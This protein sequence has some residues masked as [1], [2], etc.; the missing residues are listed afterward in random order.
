ME[1][2]AMAAAANRQLQETVVTGLRRG[3]CPTLAAPMETGDGLLVR[4]RPAGG[5]L[6][7][8]QLKA[9]AS[10]AASCGNGILEIT[11]RGNLQVR[12]LRPD[13]V[14]TLALAIDAAGIVVPPGPAI[15][16]SPLHGIDSAE[17]GDAAALEAQLRSTLAGKLQSA[18]IA[19]KLAIL[20]DGRGVFCLDH[21]SADIRIVALAGHDWLVAAGGTARV[22]WHVFS[23]GIDGAVTAVGHVLDILIATGRH[24]RARDIDIETLHAAFP[25]APQSISFSPSRTP[26]P[27][28][29]ALPDGRAVLGLRPRFG[30]MRADALRAFLADLADDIEIRLA[31]DRQLFLTGLAAAEAETLAVRAGSCGFSA[32]PVDPSANIAACAGAGA[33]ASGFYDTRKLAARIIDTAPD[34]LDGSLTVHLSG[35]AKGCAHP[36]AALTLAGRGNAY[37]LSMNG[38]AGDPPDATIA[39]GGIESAIERLAQLAGTERRAGETVAACLQRLGASTIAKALQ[40]D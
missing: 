16:L 11:A 5:A 3:A 8:A 1:G 40:Q 36:Q 6:T 32:D 29:L 2:C 25:E 34:L 9:L 39:G 31:P 35:C 33:C 4:L 15:E 38:K 28:I 20:V 23:G 30:Q 14:G 22:A 37:A 13:S 26:V 17:L 12:G 10:A 19:P 7:V 27:G 21:L 24:S 18:D